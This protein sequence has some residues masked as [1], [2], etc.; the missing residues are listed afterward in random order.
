[1]L[2]GTGHISVVSLCG[3]DTSLFCGGSV[4]PRWPPH[5]GAGLPLRAPCHSA[6]AGAGCP[7]SEAVFAALHLPGRPSS[8]LPSRASCPVAC[9]CCSKPAPSGGVECVL[10]S[11][12]AWA[13]LTALPP[14]ALV[15]LPGYLPSS[16]SHQDAALNLPAL[17]GLLLC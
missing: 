14:E 12:V 15:S 3:V 11:S 1:M 5:L 8:S 6:F 4:A 13:A 17:A 9:D 10:G 7:A 16:C 2:R